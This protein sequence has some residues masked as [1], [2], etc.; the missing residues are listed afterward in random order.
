V[1][2]N[3][4]ALMP[5][6]GLGT[7]LGNHPDDKATCAE[8]VLQAIK[9]GYRHIDT[10]HGYGTEPAVGEAVRKSGIPR[11][12]LFITT[13]LPSQHHSTVE[14]SLD[15]SLERAGLS[16]YD[17]YL[18]HWPMASG[19]KGFLEPGDSPTIAETWAQMEKVLESGK[20]KAIG[21]SNFSIKTLEELLKTAKVVPAVNQVEMHP[22]LAQNDLLEYCKEKGIIITEY[23][24]TGYAN[25]LEHPVIVKI[26]KK[27]DVS[28]A[29][30]AL[31]WA[32]QRGTTA[33]AKSSN[34]TRQKQNITLPKLDEDDMKAINGMD[35]NSR[36]CND[37]KPG[38]WGKWTKEQMG[39]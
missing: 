1:K 23:S 13:K 3:T 30:V 39:W 21:V 9:L 5:A 35:E 11:E 31:A 38:W 14:A 12:E 22:V 32:V 10:A 25:V 17:L 29:Q 34:P 6:I 2:L 20:A 16:Y 15:E 4:G 18:V 7:W 36:L 27:H 8:W 37:I 19:A 26:A 33:A 28:P 24:P